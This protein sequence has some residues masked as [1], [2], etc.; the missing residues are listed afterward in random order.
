[1]ARISDE[2]RAQ[3]PS[4]TNPISAYV[5][6]ASRL[7][8][9]PPE[10]HLGAILAPWAYEMSRFGLRV[11]STPARHWVG[12]V[13]DS[14][15]SKTSTVNRVRD[16]SEAF[17]DR[18]FKRT[19]VTVPTSWVSL[20]GSLPGVLH[21]LSQL[22]TFNG[23]TCAILHHDEATAILR[24]EDTADALN[25]LYNGRTI[26]RNLRYLQKQSDEGGTT[27]NS[28]VKPI[29]QMIVTTTPTA[30]E[31]V[32]KP[33]MVEGGLYYR[34]L[35]IHASLRKEDLMPRPLEDLEGRKWV[36][37]WWEYT[38]RELHA[39]ATHRT[40]PLYRRILFEPEAYDWLDQHL[41][42]Q[43]RDIMVAD[44]F[45]KGLVMRMSPQAQ[46]LAALYATARLRIRNNHITVGLE[47]VQ[48]AGAFMLARR[49][50][51]ASLGQAVVAP[52]E[53]FDRRQR[54]VLNALTDA[55]TRGLKRSELYRL[56]NNRVTAGELEVVLDALTERELIATAA[57][58]TGP[59]DPTTPN[60]R[61]RLYYFTPEA[62][63]AL[64]AGRAKHPLHDVRGE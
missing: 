59:S 21:K 41:F 56:F 33:E 52:N 11:G 24:R 48:A 2:I 39:R 62:A 47:E 46:Q 32:L 3:F 57:L 50:A 18:L 61:K 45:D 53:T 5:E 19:S 9:T 27:D 30:L 58:E 8:H 64:M 55:G 63:A 26:E 29:T 31:R 16:F 20:N 14:G 49:A 38:W 60:G 23:H 22:G 4:G 10:M 7:S 12:L 44:R 17:Y 28:I 43:F 36:L 6:W 35:W 1:M 51:S 34:I 40:Q 13:A 54:R 15:V 42:Y 37:D 25:E